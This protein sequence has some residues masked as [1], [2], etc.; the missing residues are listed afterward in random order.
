MFSPPSAV[1]RRMFVEGVLRGVGACRVADL[2][3][4]DGALLLHLAA[5]CDPGRATDPNDPGLGRDAGAGSDGSSQPPQVHHPWQQQQLQQQP[6]GEAGAAHAAGDATSSDG[7]HE[8]PFRELVGV[9][10]SGTALARA[11]KRLQVWPCMPP[12]SAQT[13]SAAAAALLRHARSVGTSTGVT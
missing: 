5:S 6:T 2:G 12:P 1:Q 11:Q 13:V 8:L 3:C 7:A 9:D 10:I 4:G